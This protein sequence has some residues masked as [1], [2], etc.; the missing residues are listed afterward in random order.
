MIYLLVAII[1]GLIIFMFFKAHYDVVDERSI[2]DDRLPEC[3][4]NYCIFYISDIHRRTIN[5]N[6]LNAHKKKVDI[7]VIGGD[8]TEKGVPL[9]RTEQNLKLLKQFE[10]P[11]YFVW[12]NNDY[13]VNFKK[14]NELL[15]KE[16]IV[17]LKDSYINIKRGKQMLTLIGF[18]YHENEEDYGKVDWPNIIGDYR[19]LLT[20][21][22]QSFYALDPNCQ[23]SIHTVLSGHTHGGQIRI[24]GVG[25]YQKGGLHIFRQTNIFISEGYGYTLLPFRLQTNAECHLITLKISEC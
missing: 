15:E 18:D 8:L 17:I 9:K 12:G 6:T 13:E 20:H 3:F 4:D 21:V 5:P 2:V 1:V 25:F 19:V 7:V 23:R 24:L 22:P 11:I 16:G 10:V 14:L